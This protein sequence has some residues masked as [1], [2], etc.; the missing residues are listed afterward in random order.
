MKQL[1]LAL[2][3]TVSVGNVVAQQPD[4]PPVA[5]M[6]LAEDAVPPPAT[7]SDLAWLEGRWTGTGLGGLSEEVIAPALGGQMIGMFRQSASDGTPD[8]YEFYHFAE[9]NGSLILRIK[10]FNPDLTGWEEKDEREEFRLVALSDNAAYFDGLT[11]ALIAPGELRAAVLIG[12]G[13]RADFSYS[14]VD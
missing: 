2:A 8:F 10:H 6:Q 14:K 4:A 1:W 5:V 7:I 3:V 13:S 11:F 12:G 9:E